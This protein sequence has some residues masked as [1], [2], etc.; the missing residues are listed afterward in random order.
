[1]PE[2]LALS[3]PGMEDRRCFRDLGVEAEGVEERT[4]GSGSSETLVEGRVVCFW[5]NDRC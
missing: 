3:R 5:D 1:M 4:G 2:R